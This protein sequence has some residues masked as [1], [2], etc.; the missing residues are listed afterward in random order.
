[1]DMGQ[2][3][4]DITFDLYSK[5][6]TEGELQDILDFYRSPT[7]SK[8]VSLMPQ[9]TADALKAASDSANKAILE[10]YM[11]VMKEEMT[12]LVAEL[13]AGEDRDGN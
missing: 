8:A 9:M 6:F 2:L 11:A 1:M 3:A 4:E 5:H 12:N 13:F 10:V 7:G